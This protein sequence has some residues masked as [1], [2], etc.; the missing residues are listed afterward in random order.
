MFFS[1]CFNV[2]QEITNEPFFS[3]D[4]SGNVSDFLYF[5]FTTITTTGYGDFVAGTRIGRSFAVTEA[6]IGQIYLVTVVALIVANL[7]PRKREA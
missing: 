7:R 3:N 4:D 2:T 6:L 1:F 5:S